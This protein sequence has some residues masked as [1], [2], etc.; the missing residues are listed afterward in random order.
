MYRLP[1]PS[2]PFLA[3]QFLVFWQA[4]DPSL[5][6]VI[7]SLLSPAREFYVRRGSNVS[8]RTANYG[9]EGAS[10]IKGTPWGLPAGHTSMISF[11]LKTTMASTSLIHLSV[12]F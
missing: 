10:V 8:S 7:T 9:E 2:N 3:D 6:P 1:C 4:V 11:S 5:A 12:N